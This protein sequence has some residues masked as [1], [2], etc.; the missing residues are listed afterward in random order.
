M[1]LF[2]CFV[3]RL[4][5]DVLSCHRNLLEL[6]GAGCPTMTANFGPNWVKC[7]TTLC[8]REKNNPSNFLHN[9]YL[10]ISADFNEIFRQFSRGNAEA[11]YLKIVCV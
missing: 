2:V 4:L 10:E 6:I 1:C 8:F 7:K 11:T 5:E 9:T 3:T